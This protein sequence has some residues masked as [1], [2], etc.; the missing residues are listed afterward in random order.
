[1]TKR[2]LTAYGN[3]QVDA[4]AR[5][6][7]RHP[8]FSRAFDYRELPYAHD[9]TPDDLPHI[10][11]TMRVTDLLLHQFLFGAGRAPALPLL[12][13]MDALPASAQRLS[14]PTLVFYGYAPQQALSTN[15]VTLV[16][17]VH[18]TAI[19]QG[20]LLGLSADQI[21][22]V[23]RHPDFYTPEFCQQQMETNLEA[24]A[25]REALLEP[26]LTAATF[27]RQQWRSQRLFDDLAHPR[28]AVLIHMAEQVLARLG[29]DPQR[30]GPAPAVQDYRKGAHSIPIYPSTHAGLG[31]TF[32]DSE[33]CRTA[34]GEMTLYRLIQELLDF[35]AGQDRAELQALVQFQRPFVI[36]RYDVILTQIRRTAAATRTAAASSPSCPPGGLALTPFPLA[37]SEVDL[38]HAAYAYAEAQVK[39]AWQRWQANV[40]LN[41]LPGEQFHLLPKL[42]T[43]LLRLGLVEQADARIAGVHRRCWYLNQRLRTASQEL[44]ALFGQAAIP[45]VGAGDAAAATLYTSLGERPIRQLSLLTLPA[46]VD[47]ANHTLVAAGWRADLPPAALTAPALRTWRSHALYRRVGD[48]TIRLQWHFLATPIHAA[49]EERFMGLA[50]DQEVA[51]AQLTRA[52]LLAQAAATAALG[53]PDRLLALGDA[54]TILQAGQSLNWDATLELAYMLQVARPL[55]TLLATVSAIFDLPVEQQV[56]VRLAALGEDELPCE[57]LL[58]VAPGAAG[59]QA[60]LGFH[61]RR[62]RRIAKATKAPADARSLLAYIQAVAGAARPRDLPARLW[63]RWTRRPAPRRLHKPAHN[64]VS[65]QSDGR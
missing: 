36:E 21:L 15:A 53:G 34:K 51:P 61:R 41:H 10:V 65:Q 58:Q 52:A 16:G 8:E 2:I 35:Y 3:C 32:D 48:E 45:V 37:A 23:I 6:L 29:F 20:F 9:V 38:L 57:S 1:M 49:F 31:L 60:R 30:I 5:V 46:F 55:H 56:L 47:L 39:A 12:Q 11:E 18:D 24:V 54:N 25:R 64:T 33:A 13:V 50:F 63:Q 7:M 43:N 40:D 14:M 27:L 59:W 26:A 17:A 44:L 19:L 4:L 28:R 62:W 22:A 42:H